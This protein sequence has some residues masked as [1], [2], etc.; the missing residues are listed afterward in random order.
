[1]LLVY[2]GSFFSFLFLNGGLAFNDLPTVVQMLCSSSSTGS[3]HE[4]LFHGFLCRCCIRVLY[5][6]VRVC[7]SHDDPPPTSTRPT[8]QTCVRPG[9]NT[10]DP[11]LRCQL[12]T[13]PQV[14]LC[15]R[16]V[17]PQLESFLFVVV[18]VVGGEILH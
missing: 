11:H 2:V 17:C 14:K 10:T 4:K 8:L 18:V 5:M 9:T 7:A 13:R 3:P 6:Y 1:M 16:F 15:I 12:V